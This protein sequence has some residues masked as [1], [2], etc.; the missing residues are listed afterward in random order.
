MTKKHKMQCTSLMMTRDAF[1]E[2]LKFL[3]KP[4]NQEQELALSCFAFAIFDL[5]RDLSGDE[6]AVGQYWHQLMELLGDEDKVDWQRLAVIASKI[7]EHLEA[8]QL[9]ISSGKYRVV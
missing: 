6:H 3:F 7:E 2:T 1:I 5:W 4:K 8:T 9:F